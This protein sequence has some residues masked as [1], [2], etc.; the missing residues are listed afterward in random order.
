MPLRRK[1]LSETEWHELVTEPLPKRSEPVKKPKVA[2]ASDFVLAEA[3]RASTFRE[4]DFEGQVPT[5]ILRCADELSA[6]EANASIANKNPFSGALDN[7]FVINAV[8]TDIDL[9]AMVLAGNMS[10]RSILII[11]FYGENLGLLPRI[12]DAEINLQ[13][14]NWKSCQRVADALTGDM[15][16]PTDAPLPYVETANP[17]QWNLAYKPSVK[18]S[19]ELLEKVSRLATP[20]GR[21]DKPK[22]AAIVRKLASKP[23]IT[24]DD[25]PGMG[26]ATLWAQEL[27]QDI[28]DY[29]SG[30]VSWEDV[31]RG[32]LLYGPPGCGKTRFAEAVA[33]SAG[34]FFLSTSSAN[35]LSKNDGHLGTYT[36]AMKGDFVTARLRRPTLMFI[37]EIDAVGARGSK[38]HNSAWTTGTVTALLEELD[39]SGSRDGVVVIGATNKKDSVD[40]ALLRSGRL[41]RCVEIEKPN[42]EALEAIFRV[43][44]RGVLE[45]TDFGSVTAQAAGGTGADVERWCREARR[46]ARRARREIVVAD[47]EAV[48]RVEDAETR[49]PVGFCR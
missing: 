32:I 10:G 44:L 19:R 17:I 24:L 28:A 36:K 41:D 1:S 8:P 35:W 31:D 3:V 25:C 16:D 30:I 46:I 2:H 45:D 38:D 43:H 33:N 6:K 13:P 23:V 49:N 15:S 9:P 12:A 18:S 14:L 34:M 27:V 26:K 5:V 39:G 37:D 4:T 29:K 21:P 47:L 20:E 40:P 48:V 11:T 42:A 7:P 22:P